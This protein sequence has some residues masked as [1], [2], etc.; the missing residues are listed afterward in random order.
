MKDNENLN[1]TKFFL[2]VILLCCY[3]VKNEAQDVDLEEDHGEYKY[4]HNNPF[5]KVILIVSN[6]HHRKRT[7]AVVISYQQS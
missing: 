7:C 3:I 1:G 5:L 6:P 4:N 2:I